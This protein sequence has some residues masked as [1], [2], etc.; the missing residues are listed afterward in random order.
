MWKA[1]GLPFES[2]IS[3]GCGCSSQPSVP[4]IKQIWKDPI[5]DVPRTDIE[6]SE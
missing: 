1:K 5:A 3:V 2:N 4:E 6:K